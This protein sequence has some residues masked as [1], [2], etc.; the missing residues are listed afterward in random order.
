MQANLKMAPKP[1]IAVQSVGSNSS[2]GT[3]WS[4]TQNKLSECFELFITEFQTQID[5]Y[6]KTYNKNLRESSVET[7]LTKGVASKKEQRLKHQT[8]LIHEESL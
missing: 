6:F 4:T 3:G 7:Q 2:G 5:F 1:S 8:F